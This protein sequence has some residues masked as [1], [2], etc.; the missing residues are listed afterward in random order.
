MHRSLLPPIPTAMPSFSQAI[1]EPEY[2]GI[3]T[4]LAAAGIAT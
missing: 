2:E 1:E 4:A 3:R